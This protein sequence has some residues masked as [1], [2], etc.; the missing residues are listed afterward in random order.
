MNKN[1]SCVNVYDNRTVKTIA[2]I[3]EGKQH[4]INTVYHNEKYNFYWYLN[5]KGY[6]HVLKVKAMRYEGRVIYFTVEDMTL[7]PNDTLSSK[8][9]G[10]YQTES[11]VIKI[12]ESWCN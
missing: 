1:V 5:S 6:Y 12:I 11:E 7:K 9:C 3:T 4:C 8:N 10:N 2:G